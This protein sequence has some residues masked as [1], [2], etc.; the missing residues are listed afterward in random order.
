MIRFLA[1]VSVSLT[2]ANVLFILSALHYCLGVTC[3]NSLHTLHTRGTRASAIEKEI[4][5]INRNVSTHRFMCSVKSSSD[6][7]ISIGFDLIIEVA[8]V[9]VVYVGDG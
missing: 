1:F 6:F 9:F 7:W 3:Q 2:K 8:V 4:Q 5:T